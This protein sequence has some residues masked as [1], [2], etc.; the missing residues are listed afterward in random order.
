MRVSSFD[1][2]PFVHTEP[3]F[4]LNSQSPAC[5]RKRIACTVLALSVLVTRIALP[6]SAN[7]GEAYGE[8]DQSTVLQGS[9]LSGLRDRWLQGPELVVSLAGNTPVEIVH[10]GGEQVLAIDSAAD[11]SESVTLHPLDLVGAE[12]TETQCDDQ[13]CVETRFRITEAAPDYSTSTMSDHPDNRDSWLYRVE[14][15]TEPSPTGEWLG[16]CDASPDTGNDTDMGLFATGRWPSA[17][18]FEPTGYT[19]SCARGVVAKCARAWGYKPWKTLRNAE[20]GPVSLLP[21]HLACTRAA[22]AEYCGDGVSYTED[23]TAVYIGDVYGFNTP[24][25]AQGFALEAAFD[26]DRAVFLRHSRIHW[27]RPTCRRDIAEAPRDSALLHIWSRPRRN[28]PGHR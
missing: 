16:V 9:V 8:V 2:R 23:G 4:Q 21:L 18:G 15:Q 10:F 7:P 28:P 22:R 13:R 6:V 27:L 11:H 19:F 25:P 26:P 24:R 14:H 20:H 1:D 12:W 3:V 17:G 5:H